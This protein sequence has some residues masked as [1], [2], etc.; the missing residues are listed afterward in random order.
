MQVLKQVKSSLEEPKNASWRHNVMTQLR[1]GLTHPNF[2]FFCSKSMHCRLLS[3]DPVGKST[4]TSTCLQKV[5]STV[6]TANWKLILPNWKK[7]GG[8][9]CSAQRGP[10]RGLSSPQEG[11]PSAIEGPLP[12]KGPPTH[13]EGPSV[14][15]PECGVAELR[16]TR[17]KISQVGTFHQKWTHVKK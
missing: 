11:A 8:P 3:G 7:I 15:V 16:A 17:H 1:H 6:S 12:A 2:P 13:G 9:S 14:R 5:G 10:R 4:K